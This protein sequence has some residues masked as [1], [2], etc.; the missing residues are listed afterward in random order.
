[1]NSVAD[2]ITEDMKTAMK[3]GD[4]A[5]LNVLRNLKSALK[6]TAIEKGGAD[7]VLDEAEVMAV[8]RKQIKQRQDSAASYREGGREDLAAT[9]EAEVEVLSGYL[10]APLSEEE[11]L[12]L[13]DEAVA[14]IGASTMKDM[15]K[16]MALLQERTGGRAD[17]KTLSTVVRGRLAG[18]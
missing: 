15:G 11:V 12:R 5:R 2:Q 18:Q 1:M 16:V 6:N 3:A 9:E 10:P 7:A 8:L 14:E 4:K 17:N 13:V